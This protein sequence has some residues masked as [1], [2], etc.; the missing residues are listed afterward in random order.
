MKEKVKPSLGRRGINDLRK[1][2]T[3]ST[4]EPK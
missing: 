1:E 2:E 3:P 4:C